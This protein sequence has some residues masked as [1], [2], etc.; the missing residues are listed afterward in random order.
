MTSFLIAIVYKIIKFCG[1]KPQNHC[2]NDS[3]A[4]KFI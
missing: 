4:I 2:D 1:L 3:F